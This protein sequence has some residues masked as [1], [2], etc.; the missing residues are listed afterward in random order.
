MVRRAH[1]LV[2]GALLH[3]T[4]YGEVA[5]QYQFDAYKNADGG[6]RTGTEEIHLA[7]ASAEHA[8]GRVD[9][10]VCLR[11]HLS[12][13]FVSDG[14]PSGTL[15]G[16]AQLVSNAEAGFR[17][18]RLYEAWSD[19]ATGP[20]SFRVGAYDLNSEFD[21]LESGS[22]FINSSHG[23]GFDIG[24][25]GVN[26]PSIFPIIGLGVRVGYVVGSNTLRVAFLD[27]VPG[28]REAPDEQDFSWRQDDGALV[29]G[30]WSRAG[31]GFKMI[32]GAW[33]Y[34]GVRTSDLNTTDDTNGLYI[35]GERRL[36]VTGLGREV[37]AFGR[38]G[39]ADGPSAEF[40][41][42]LGAGVQTSVPLHRRSD[43]Q[44]GVA[45]AY[46][47]RLNPSTINDEAIG[48]LNIEATYSYAINNRFALQ[49]N[50]QWIRR[51]SGSKTIDDAFVFGIRAT[52]NI[53][54]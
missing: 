9:C 20:L 3:G 53:S 49:P 21:I 44:M 51:P 42:F 14:Q 6:L 30:E 54:Q 7:T 19:I 52:I 46:A 38:A 10:A 23:I 5:F 15:V 35:R 39:I 26:G 22:L 13:L 40:P 50:A 34:A 12:G 36:F 45:V 29:V 47:G 32:A 41:L 27:G 37:W 48:E 33:S 2:A 18:L 43:D 1:I 28:D 16:D 24:Q 8:F 17:S 4:A 31:E 25:T 11:T